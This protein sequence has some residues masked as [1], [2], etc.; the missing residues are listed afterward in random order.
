MTS[1]DSSLHGSPVLLTSHDIVQSIL[2]L[3]FRTQVLQAKRGTNS[4]DPQG[5]PPVRSIPSRRQGAHLSPAESPRCCLMGRSSTCGNWSPGM[6]TATEA[7]SDRSLGGK[8]LVVDTPIPR[9]LVHRIIDT[10]YD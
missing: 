5:A 4:E 3:E 6:A 7:M 8:T 2:D 10:R 1:D 9:I